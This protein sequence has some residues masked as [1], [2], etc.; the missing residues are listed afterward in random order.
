MPEVCEVESPKDRKPE[1]T[2][3]PEVGKTA[4]GLPYFPV[5]LLAFCPPLPKLLFRDCFT[6][7]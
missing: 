2:E 7:L 6:L 4:F 3:S 1:K 5:F